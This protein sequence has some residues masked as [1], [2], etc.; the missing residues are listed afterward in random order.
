MPVLP[1]PEA[2]AWM[3]FDYDS[4]KRVILDQETFSSSMQTAGRKNPD[5]LIFHDPPRHSKL[6]ALIAQAFTPR[7]IANLE[8]RIREISRGLLDRHLSSGAMDWVAD[9]AVPLPLLVITEMLGAPVEDQPRYR[10]WSDVILRLSYTISQNEET[11]IAVAEYYNVSTEMGAYVAELVEDRRRTPTDDLLTRLVEAEVDGEHLTQ[12]ELLGF[13]QLLIVAGHETTTNLLANTLICLLDNPG[14]F[15]RLRAKPD[16]LTAA[17]EEVL[18]YR[19]PVQFV[20]RATRREVELNGQRIPKGKLLMPVIGAANRDPK[21]FP[22][23]HRFQIDR[24]PNPHIAFGHGI[25]F[26]LGAALSR[27][28]ARVALTDFFGRTNNLRLASDAPWQPRPA[29]HVHGPQ[30]LPVRFDA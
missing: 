13:F 22:D 26:C 30:S 11:A 24:E 15:A 25:H 14:E 27:L 4:V 16:L 8:Q 9:F 3:L 5:W 12:R 7:S 2:D 10:K 20:F 23:P 1:V 17:V 19:S 28:E 6:R 18:R 29:L 21:Y